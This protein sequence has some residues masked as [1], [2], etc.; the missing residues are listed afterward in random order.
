MADYPLSN[1]SSTVPATV[2]TGTNTSAEGHPSSNRNGSTIPLSDLLDNR[3]EDTTA[4]ASTTNQVP[5]GSVNTV[6]LSQTRQPELAHSSEELKLQ[7]QQ[8][9]SHLQIQS[10]DPNQSQLQEPIDE[11]EETVD[12]DTEPIRNGHNDTLEDEEDEKDTEDDSLDNISDDDDN[13]SHGV[14]HIAKLYR[15]EHGP[16]TDG[17]VNQFICKWQNCQQPEQLNLEEMISHLIDGHVGQ[18]S[19]YACEW[20]Q[21]TQKGSPQESKSVL[22]HHSR[23]HIPQLPFFCFVPECDRTFS[24]TATLIKHVRVIHGYDPITREVEPNENSRPK[25]K[26]PKEPLAKAKALN[27]GLLTQIRKIREK[28]S[29]YDTREND[30]LDNDLTLQDESDPEATINQL[31]R[32]LLWSLELQEQL[33]SELKTAKK[34]KNIEVLRKE[35]L[36]DELLATQLG[37]DAAASLAIS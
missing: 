18:S 32:Q 7:Q 24:R 4:V 36:F 9:Q 15:Q 10:Q 20:D 21:C 3:T 19:N 12:E 22:V 28:E 16:T 33:E 35:R 2:V 6:Q 25:E 11:G 34:Q 27:P 37:P 1:G 5:Q 23:Q 8:Q 31:K 14:N 30:E 29:L 13:T 17:E 26:E